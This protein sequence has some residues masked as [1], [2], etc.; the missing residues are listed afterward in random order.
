MKHIPSNRN[1]AIAY[2]VVL[3]LISLLFG[4]KAVSSGT[5]ESIPQTN[6]LRDLTLDAEAE[7]EARKLLDGELTKCQDDYFSHSYFKIIYYV[8]PD[9]KPSS[10]ADIWEQNAGVSPNVYSD[11]LNDADRRNGVLWKG[12]VSFKS[13]SKRRYAKVNENEDKNSLSQW[14]NGGEVF[15]VRLIK[16]KQS[17]WMSQDYSPRPTVSRT[18]SIA[19][20][21]RNFDYNWTNGTPSQQFQTTERKP[22]SEEEQAKIRDY[23]LKQVLCYDINGSPCKFK[24]IACEETS[25]QRVECPQIPEQLLK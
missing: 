12:F 15:R 19:A 25:Y 22:C 9:V 14:T 8:S 1:T 10:F 16:T 4:C 24:E 7:R 17:G 13:K 3:F 2:G 20:D 11:T 5:P 18:I 23:N 6:D 21:L